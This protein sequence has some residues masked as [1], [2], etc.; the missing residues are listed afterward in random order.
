MNFTQQ[1]FT[2]AQKAIMQILVKSRTELMKHYG[3]A[4]YETKSDNSIVTHMDKEMELKLKQALAKMDKSVGF[5]GEEHGREG[6][7]DDYWLID[8][9]DGTESYVR[10]IPTPCNLLS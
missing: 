8:P 6:N 2:D 7:K 3:R 10:G 4:E 1:Y 9:I 5:W